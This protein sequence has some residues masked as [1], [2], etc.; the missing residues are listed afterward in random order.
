M[1]WGVQWYCDAHETMG[2]YIGWA[3][4]GVADSGRPTTFISREIAMDWLNTLRE[5]TSA[6]RFRIRRV[7]A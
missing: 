4:A 2:G 1:T 3:W 7:A 6:T 5:D